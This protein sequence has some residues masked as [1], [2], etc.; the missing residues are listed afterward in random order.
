LTHR[1]DRL[2]GWP[3][4]IRTLMCK[5]K[6]HLFESAAELEFKRVSADRPIL[7]GE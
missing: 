2:P 3:Y 1:G 7:P 4:R 5:V 6:I